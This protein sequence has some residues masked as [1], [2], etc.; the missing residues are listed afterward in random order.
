MVTLVCYHSAIVTTV[1]KAGRRPLGEPGTWSEPQP[2]KSPAMFV[3]KLSPDEWAE[4]CRLRDGGQSFA[5]IA[6]RF[7]MNPATIARRARK[8]GWAEPAG[9]PASA[10]RGA[11]ARRPSPATADIR[12]ALALRLFSVI[13]V[14][15]RIMEL[16]MHKQLEAYQNS[17]AGTEPPVT[18][19]DQ[20]DTLAALIESINQVTEMASEPAPTADGRRRTANPELTAL[21]S[22]IDPAGLA[23]AS[24]KDALRA[25][26]AERLGKLFPRS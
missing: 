21:S 5:A 7:G 26:L 12:A 24:E 14:R 1:A 22:D 13:A 16:Q 20:R 11:K 8:E 10:A 4:A 3:S 9:R 6:G 18:A 23:I 2:Q 15:I 25:E 19:S 17:A